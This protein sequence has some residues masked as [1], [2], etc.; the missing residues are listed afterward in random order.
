MQGATRDEQHVT[1]EGKPVGDRI[2][3]VELRP[4]VTHHDERGELSEA[5]NPAWGVHPDPLVYVYLTTIRPGRIKGWV[6]H[7]LQDDRVFVMFGIVKIVLF[8]ARGGSP[9]KGM[10]NEFHVGE[11]NRG[12]LVV[13]RGVYHAFQNVGLVD[14]AFINMPTRPYDHQNPDKTR[15]PIDTDQIPYRFNDRLGW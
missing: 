12:L 9:T 6:M 1:P 10:I 13:P 2:E 14:A 5:Y 11:R 7:D 4:A 8:D 3:G 15:L